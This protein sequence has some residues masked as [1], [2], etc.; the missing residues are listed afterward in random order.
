MLNEKKNGVYQWPIDYLQEEH[1]T[2]PLIVSVLLSLAFGIR[3]GIVDAEE[4][5]FQAL[6]LSVRRGYRV[7]AVYPAVSVQNVL[8][9]VLAVYAV[10]GI[11]DVLAGRDDQGERY[12][13]DH[14]QAVMQAE[15]GAVDVDVRDFYETL[16]TAK[17]VQH[18]GTRTIP[19]VRDQRLR[20]ATAIPQNNVPAGLRV[21]PRCSSVRF[22]HLPFPIS[23]R[24]FSH[25]RV[26]LFVHFSTS[27]RGTSLQSLE[28]TILK[29]RMDLTKKINCTFSYLVCISLSWL[30]EKRS[31][32]LYHFSSIIV[33]AVPVCKKISSSD[34]QK[35]YILYILFASHFN[36]SGILIDIYIY[37]CYL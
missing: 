8:G 11:A 31:V 6:S 23:R 28:V 3:F 20:R 17:Y 7:R 10:D 15:D 30:P 35:I 4:G 16:Q 33:S 19:E 29:T 27:A 2:N 37:I 36:H 32:S 18:L 26:S 24:L 14:S 21:P 34:R 12:Q 25:V 1:E 5:H 13:Q 9:Q 22:L